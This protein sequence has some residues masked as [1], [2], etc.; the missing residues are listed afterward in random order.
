TTRPS[1]VPGG[2]PSRRSNGLFGSAPLAHMLLLTLMAC[3]AIQAVAAVPRESAQGQF[4]GRLIF[5]RQHYAAPQAP[6]ESNHFIDLWAEQSLRASAEACN[7]RDNHTL[8]INSH[9]K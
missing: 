6:G 5:L 1:A 4:G 8:F 9:G 3:E 2:R 7:L